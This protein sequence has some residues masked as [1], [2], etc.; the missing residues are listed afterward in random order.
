MAAVGL[1]LAAPAVL[2][3][4]AVA[5]LAAGFVVLITPS[6]GSSGRAPAERTLV[7]F[8]AP[9]DLTPGALGAVLD[10]RSACDI[11]ERRPP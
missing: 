9:C 5:G 10:D 6:P 11:P 4:A 7:R 3:T 8:I 1:G 2:G